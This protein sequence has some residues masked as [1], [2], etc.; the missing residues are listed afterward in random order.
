MPSLPGFTAARYLH[1]PPQAVK[2]D[3]LRGTQKMSFNVTAVL[4]RERINHIADLRN[5]GDGE[6]VE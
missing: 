1:P 3:V 4:A 6:F 5:K 2:I